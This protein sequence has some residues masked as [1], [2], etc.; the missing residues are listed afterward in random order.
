MR[1]TIH[2]ES[3]GYHFKQE[4]TT[5]QNSRYGTVQ[6][7]LPIAINKDIKATYCL[8]NVEKNTQMV[9]ITPV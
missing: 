5:P 8:L 1:R 2:F 6:R 7:I 9:Y 3:A 4:M